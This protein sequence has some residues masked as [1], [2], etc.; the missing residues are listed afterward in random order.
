VSGDPTG[1]KNLSYDLN[2]LGKL[3]AEGEYNDKDENFINGFLDKKIRQ[4][5]K[6]TGELKSSLKYLERRIS[7]PR[8]KILVES[9]S[10]KDKS[11]SEKDK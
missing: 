1:M 4:Q 8:N 10:E 9:D 6:M 3:T 11:D 7:I 2:S 5:A